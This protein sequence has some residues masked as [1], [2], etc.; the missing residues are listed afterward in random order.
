MEKP[1]ALADRPSHQATVCPFPLQQVLSRTQAAEYLGISSSR[2]RLLALLGGGPDSVRQSAGLVH[3]RKDDLDQY[4]AGLFSKA[5]LSSEAL[6]RYRGLRAA[7]GYAGRDGFMDMA[8]RDELLQA[9]AYV[10]GRLVI[11]LGMVV[12]VLSHTPLS[13]LLFHMK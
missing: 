7:S 8:S 13:R 5:G 6:N 9:S 3:F 1:P 12:I 11:L 2:L 10:G 4:S